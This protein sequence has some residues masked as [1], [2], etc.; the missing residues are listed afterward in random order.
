MLE[1]FIRYFVVIVL[2]AVKNLKMFIEQFIVMVLISISC[3]LPLWRGT[4]E[5]TTRWLYMIGEEVVR[6]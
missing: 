2:I 4:T 5:V 1:Q 3:L 6:A